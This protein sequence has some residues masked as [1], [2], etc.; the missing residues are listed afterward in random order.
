MKQDKF[1]TLLILSLLFLF[2]LNANAEERKLSIFGLTIH[3]T[4]TNAFAANEMTNKLTQDGR[5]ALNPQINVTFYKDQNISNY[6][7]VIDCY[8]K[9]AIYL[10]RGKIYKVEDNLKLG[11]MLGL[12]ARQYPRAEEFGLGRVGLYQFLPT[13]SLLMEYSVNEKVSIR[14]NSNIVINFVDL[15]FSF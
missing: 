8:A 12:Y 4:S 3:G 10:G 11:Y 14:V 9:P 6:S 2:C 5:I 7:F 1:I 15:A 13:P